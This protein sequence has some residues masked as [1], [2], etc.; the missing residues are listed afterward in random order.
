MQESSSAPL[1]HR[2]PDACQRIGLGRSSLYELIKAGRLKTVRIAGRTLV[3]ES[4]LQRLV[5]EAEA[6]AVQS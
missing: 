3:P 5:A 1:A 2:I 4:E 6:E